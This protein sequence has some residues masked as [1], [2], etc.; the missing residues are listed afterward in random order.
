MFAAVLDIRYQALLGIRYQASGIQSQ[1]TPLWKMRSRRDP[2]YSINEI[3]VTELLVY[4]FHLSDLI[5][6]QS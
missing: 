4:Q 1:G 3:N 5:P 6:S 2:A